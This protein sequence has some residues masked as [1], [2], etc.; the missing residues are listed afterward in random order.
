MTPP[1]SRPT[2]PAA[3][4]P[5]S[6]TDGGAPSRLGRLFAL[7]EGWYFETDAQLRLTFLSDRAE[8]GLGADGQRSGWAIGQ[9][10]DRLLI[11][12]TRDD[13]AERLLA[14]RLPLDRAV[15]RKSGHG[16]PLRLVVSAAPRVD[17]NGTFL[18]YDGTARPLRAAPP[19]PPADAPPGGTPGTPAADDPRWLEAMFQHSF[20]FYGLLDAEGRLLAASPSSLAFIG[21]AFA[22]VHLKPFWE[23]P[24]WTH[25]P[26]EQA[27]LREAIKGAAQGRFA[28]FETSHRDAQGETRFLDV[29]LTPIHDERGQVGLI[30]AEGRDVSELRL[31]RQALLK[32]IQFLN[33]LSDTA[34]TPIFALD[35]QGHYSF[36]NEAFQLMIGRPAH[37]ILGHSMYEV[38]PRMVTQS[39]HAS[40]HDLLHSGGTQRYQAVLV[41]SDGSR[42][43]VVVAQA[44][45]QDETG[46]TDGVVSLIT[47]ITDLK[48]AQKRAEDFAAASSDWLW[49]TDAD[50]RLVFISEKAAELTG[51]LSED[52]F[53]PDGPLI[54]QD[55]DQEGWRQHMDDM[56]AR[57]PFKDFVYRTRPGSDGVSRFIR[58]S[59]VPLFDRHG[60]FC[61]YRGTGSD[62]T[63]QMQAAEDLRAAMRAAEAANRTKSEFLATMSHEL[64]TPLNAIIGFSETM[65]MGVFGQVSNPAYRGYVNDIKASGE[66]LLTLVNDILDVSRVEIGEIELFEED[67]ALADLTG[68]VLRLVQPRARQAGIV[69]TITVPVDLPRLRCDQTRI[70]QALTNLL[71]NAVKFT[72]S[73]GSVG[74]SAWRDEAD[75]TLVMEVAD[76]GIGMSPEQ[77]QRALK[78]FAQVDSSLAR[79]Y[80]GAGLG[81]PLAKSLTELHG[82]TL[83]IDSAE[84]QGTRV[85]LTLPAERLVMSPAG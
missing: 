12:D 75:G 78:P 52:A 32:N 25:S 13:P 4:S 51:L 30:V 8:G 35:G 9:R 29:S 43:D 18:G 23:T 2:C 61:G 37:E 48:E 47:D 1:P 7:M 79:K 68:S 59:G 54:D 82:G 55:W 76:S 81:L 26:T 50:N 49:Q 42:R 33:A 28:R 77:A 5:L 11:A 36:C 83:S 70:K 6:S 15:L 63:A 84:G 3:A 72:P 34:L 53:A 14:G 66:H 38:S 41:Y 62:I 57:R 60:L 80:E 71:I 73:G 20:Q 58:V 64:R 74:L 31:A 21:R 16:D 10:L 44:V 19:P 24:W 22:E 85:R 46:A 67:V 56:A 69:P 39:P 17:G 27:R 65:A 45:Y 40:F